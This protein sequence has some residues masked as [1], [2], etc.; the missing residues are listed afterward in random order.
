LAGGEARF[1]TGPGAVNERQ[2]R[3]KV[4]Y[5][6]FEDERGR[7]AKLLTGDQARRI[8]ANIA[9][10]LVLMDRTKNKAPSTSLGAF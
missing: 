6:Y 8:A 9:K 2:L 3:E 7:R 5:L 10:L 1:T 4:A